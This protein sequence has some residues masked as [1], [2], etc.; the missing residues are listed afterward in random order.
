MATDDVRVSVLEDS[1]VTLLL[2]SK[3]YLMRDDAEGLITSKIKDDPDGIELV[4]VKKLKKAT[5][6]RYGG[7][8]TMCELSFKIKNDDR[9]HKAFFARITK[10]AYDANDV[11]TAMTMSLPSSS[12]FPDDE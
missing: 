10:A 2:G 11:F 4:D 8:A 1:W 3:V 5:G 7:P 6:C 9:E 12:F